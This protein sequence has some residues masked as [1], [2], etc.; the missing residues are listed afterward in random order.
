M[1]QKNFSHKDF[2]LLSE[3][4]NSEMLKSTQWCRA[5]KLP[6]NVKE[7]GVML[8]R[9]SQKRQT[10]DLFIQIDNNNIECVKETVFLGEPRWAYVM[11]VSHS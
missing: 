3:I 6:I 9:P 4:L 10:L 2:S 11:E 7:N 5:N 1:T 8:L